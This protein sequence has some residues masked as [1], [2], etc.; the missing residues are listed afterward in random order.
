MSIH[1]VL[2]RVGNDIARRQTVQ[3]AVVPHGD[4]VVNGDGVE[5]GCIAAHAL[6]LLA[7]YLPYLVQMGMTRH[8]L[9]E[10]IDDCYDWFPELL[11]FHSCGHPQ[12]T[13][14]SHSPSLS[15]NSTSQLMFHNAFS[16]YIYG[17]AKLLS[18]YRITNNYLNI[19]TKH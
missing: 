11:T 9:C 10:R 5:L 12:C 18:F 4:A 6:N 1:H 14:A 3:H 7:H 16:Y 17:T 13:G 19:F 2:H 8:K 15:A